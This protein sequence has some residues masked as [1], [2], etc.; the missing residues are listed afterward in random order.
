MTVLHACE[1]AGVDIPRFCYHSCLSIVGNC[2]MCLVEVE[3]TPKPVA[4]CAMPALP[5]QDDQIPGR[6]S[7]ESGNLNQLRQDYNDN[8]SFLAT[9]SSS[10]KTL[11]H[12]AVMA[13]QVEIV[14]FLVPLMPPS[15]LEMK[16]D[17]NNYTALALAAITSGNTKIAEYIVKGRS[18]DLVGIEDKNGFIPVVLASAK[19]HKHMTRYLFKNTLIPDLKKNNGYNGV[20][21]LCNY[22]AWKLLNR[23]DDL[24]TDL[25][26][27]GSPRPLTALARVPSAFPSGRPVKF[28]D[29]LG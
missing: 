25:E 12:Y 16:E 5:G 26:V 24:P 6:D 17:K 18:R 29:C 28:W 14:K 13:G 10:G 3:K 15:T 9:P 27:D 11:L 1:I 19:G 21:L 20:Y 23:Y 4:S 7:V 2:R 22:I 8:P